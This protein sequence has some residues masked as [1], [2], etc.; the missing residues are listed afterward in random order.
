MYTSRVD[1]SHWF[2]KPLTGCTMASWLANNIMLDS[3]NPSEFVNLHA[4]QSNRW[5]AKLALDFAGTLEIDW[6]QRL[7][8]LCCRGQ[9]ARI[10]RECAFREK[11]EGDKT[12]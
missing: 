10:S 8:H 6:V 11:G 3:L 9:S 2:I 4:E 7:C 1:S 12:T 5:L